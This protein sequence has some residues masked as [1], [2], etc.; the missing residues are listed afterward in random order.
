MLLNKKIELFWKYKQENNI[1]IN[2]GI[3]NKEL[4]IN[5]YIKV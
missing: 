4:V 1:Y 3:K 2:F 5:I